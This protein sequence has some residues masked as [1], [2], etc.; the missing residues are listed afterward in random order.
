M[1]TITL[2]LVVLFS[3]L[4]F[5][6]NK[7]DSSSSTNN[8]PQ[9]Q[10]QT[11]SNTQTQT[12]STGESASQT[13]NQKADE[14]IPLEFDK[15]NIPASVKY[16]GNIMAGSRW[17]DK[18]GE[19]LLIITETDEQ[20]TNKGDER[21]LSK[22]LFGYCYLIDG[23]K[24]TLLWDIN[25]FIKECPL[26]MKLEYIPNSLSVTDLNS[27]GKAE[28]TFLYRMSCKGD[29]SPDALKLMMHEGN[30]KYAIRGTTRIEFEIDGKKQSEGGG[31]TPDAAFKTAPESFLP[32]AEE[33]WDKFRIQKP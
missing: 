5:S 26:D 31:A 19:N 32:Y 23:D 3:F 15:K 21:L 30:T 6:C 18:N 13:L 29:V 1:K 28:N 8:Q 2:S 4:L 7:K 27:D 12:G 17:L 33:Q 11:N 25:D 9:S 20:T 10:Q 24:A 22:E 14:L 16:K